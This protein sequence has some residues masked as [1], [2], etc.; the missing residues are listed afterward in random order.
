M[1]GQLPECPNGKGGTVCMAKRSRCYDEAVLWNDAPIIVAMPWANR[2]KVW[3]KRNSGVLQKSNIFESKWSIV[4]VCPP[5][6]PPLIEWPLLRPQPRFLL[7]SFSHR[8]AAGVGSR[9]HQHCR[10]HRHPPPSFC[11]W[12]QRWQLWQHK[13]ERYILSKVKILPTG[14]LSSNNKVLQSYCRSTQKKS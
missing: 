5:L 10:K 3:S 2:C 14:H 6:R 11:C 1:G 9:H 4:I 13:P 12:S 8:P 7:L